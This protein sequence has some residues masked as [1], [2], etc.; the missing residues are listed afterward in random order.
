[1]Q[2]ITQKEAN[3]TPIVGTIGMFDGVHLGH[4]SLIEH[5]QRE[6]ASRN[7]ASAVVTFASHPRSVLHPDKMMPLLNT[8]NERFH[9]LEMTGI[10]YVIVLNFTDELANFSAYEFIEY[11]HRQYSLKALCIGYDH[12]FGHNR[13]EGFD[14]Y[15]RHGKDI[16]VEIIQSH[17]YISQYGAISSSFI[18]KNLLAGNTIQANEMLGYDYYLTGSV[19][20]GNQIGRKIGFPTANIAPEDINK[21]IPANGAYAVKVELEDGSIHN[22]MMNIG[23]RPTVANVNNLSIEVHLFDFI[24]DLYGKRLK[25]GFVSYL[26]PEQQFD[27]I[28]SL[29]LALKSDRVKAMEMLQK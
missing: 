29:T 12:R 11:L 19:I 25:I 21:L 22:G 13:T 23:T 17:P 4:R 3:T 10:D 20:R 18:R 7:M 14:D 9:H 27:S 24:G 28:E 15:C 8:K 5:V 6:A 1:M 26:R 2:I 16:G